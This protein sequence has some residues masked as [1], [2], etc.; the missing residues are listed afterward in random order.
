MNNIKS[1]E[2]G[3]IDLMKFICSIIVVSIHTSSFK[4]I[5]SNLHNGYSI[6]TKL[7]VPFFFITAGY[8]LFRKIKI[9]KSNFKENKKIII[10]YIKRLTLLYCLWSFIYLLFDLIKWIYQGGFKMKYIL[11][12]IKDFFFVGLPEILWYFPALIF[13]IIVIAYLLKYLSINKIVL[14]ASIFYFLGLL[15]S[16]Y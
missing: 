1:A 15:E 16:T 6:I 5:N 11:I 9:E 13:A 4:D 2:F 8:F 14:I 3:C 10:K 12:Y 7:A